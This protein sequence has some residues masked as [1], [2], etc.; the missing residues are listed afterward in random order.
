[1][2]GVSER[3]PA[4]LPDAAALQRVATDHVLRGDHLHLCDA[5]G[6]EREA[7]VVALG[8]VG[9]ANRQDESRRFERRIGVVHPVA[10]DGARPLDFVVELVNLDLADAH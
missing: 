8:A 3:A 9:G 10:A 7:A 2:V 6:C 4:I 5:R 1:V